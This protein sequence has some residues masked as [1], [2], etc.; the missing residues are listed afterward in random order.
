MKAR[1]CQR[2]VAGGVVSQV[3]VEDV[4]LGQNQAGKEEVQ[5]LPLIPRYH[6]IRIVSF[7]SLAFL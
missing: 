2:P 1:L 5:S 3:L 6:R 7:I 4:S